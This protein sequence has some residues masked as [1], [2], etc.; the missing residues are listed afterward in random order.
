MAHVALLKERTV[1]VL[2][3]LA[4]AVTF[5]PGTAPRAVAAKIPVAAPKRSYGAAANEYG[6]N[7]P[8]TITAKLAVKARAAT[9]NSEKAK[10]HRQKMA[11]TIALSEALNSSRSFIWVTYRGKEYTRLRQPYNNQLFAAVNIFV[12]SVAS[13][14]C[15]IFS[16]PI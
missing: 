11:V 10:R 9:L 13:K 14:A 16:S 8:Q 6:A 12:E 1:P 4:G 2:A 5:C 7:V 3:T 15:I